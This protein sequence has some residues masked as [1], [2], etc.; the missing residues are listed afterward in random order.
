MKN[1]LEMIT[2]E[3]EGTGSGGG[4]AAAD[5]GGNAPPPAAGGAAPPTA[6]APPP[7]S[8]GAP[9]AGPVP[10]D[11]QAPGNS[12]PAEIYKPEGVP[13]H[14]LGKSDK[15]TM[16]NVAKALRGY[17][18]KDANAGV[19]EKAEAYAEFAGEVPET[20]KPHLDVLKGDKLFERI[21]ASAFA[22]KV[23]V[24]VFQRQVTEFLSVAAEM[25][26]LEPPVNAAAELAELVPSAAKHLPEAEQKLATE[27]RMNDN[28]GFLDAMVA[29]GAD[30]GGLSKDDAEFAKAMMGDSAKGHR[31]FEWA[32]AAAGGQGGGGPAMEFGAAPANDARSD[33][34]RRAGLPEN[35]WG[36]AK[37]NK[38]SYDALQADYQKL[39]S[40]D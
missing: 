39:P 29:R 26:V 27:K 4:A 23:P 16:D 10:G 33:L 20:I 12:P 28:F 1:L 8:D 13:D 7:P 9:P 25:G 30:K 21:A 14:M 5:P 11:Q 24:P 35:T 40:N 22:D 36:H 32:R 3:A 38:A 31:F 17:R 15:E 2:R 19:P 6:G 34:S 37:F 18:D